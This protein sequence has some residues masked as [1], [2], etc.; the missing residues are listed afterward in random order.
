MDILLYV[1]IMLFGVILAKKKLIPESIKLK[2]SH[3]Q[4]IS[5]IF[6]L[7]VLGYKLGSDEHLIENIHLLGLQSFIIAVF[8]MVFTILLVFIV[9]KKGDR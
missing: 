4:T 8:A 7:F 2:L 9:F 3:L 6:L 1:V 5:L